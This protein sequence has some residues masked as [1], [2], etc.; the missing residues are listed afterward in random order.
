LENAVK[1]LEEF[2]GKEE[3]KRLLGLLSIDVKTAGP[4]QIAELENRLKETPGDPVVLV[5]LGAIYERDGAADKAIEIYQTAL[6]KSPQDA[7]T[8]FKLAQLYAKSPSQAQKALELAKQAHSAAPDDARISALL[9]RLVFLKG[10][11]YKWS[12]N[13]LEESARRLPADSQLS[14][15]LAWAKYSLGRLPEA[16]AA[17]QRAVSSDEKLPAQKLNDAKRF[18]PLVAGAT[19]STPDAKVATEAEKVLATEPDYVPALMVSALAQ[20]ASGNH[21]QAALVYDKILARYPLFAP[22]NRNLAILCCNHLSDDKK[23]YDLAVKA[24]DSFPQDAIL[25]KTLGILAYRKSDYPRAAQLLKQSIQARPGDGESL[26]YLGMAQ[27][28]LK[29]KSESKASLQQA[30]PMNLTP[31]QAADAKR[32]IAEL[33]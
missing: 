1:S 23:A 28:Q 20:E 33:K 9:G 12:A 32:I 7:Q 5:R 17:M 14:Y 29:A 25:A 30:L 19:S 6:K 8:M 2:P 3:A 26:Y 16:E 27:Y 11:D 10:D 18:L 22:A 31:Q 15:D 21:K 13:L 4:A 24:R